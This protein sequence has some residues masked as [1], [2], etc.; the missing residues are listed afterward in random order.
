MQP[1]NHI[2]KVL[3]LSIASLVMMSLS[4]V[5]NAADLAPEIT[6]GKGEACVEDKD[7]MRRNHMDL[8]RH[9][10]DETVHKGNRDIKHSLKDCISCHAIDGSDGKALTVS[11]PK[12]FCRSCH[13]Y[14]AVS[15]DCFQCHASRPELETLD[16]SSEELKKVHE[17]KDSLF[18][19]KEFEDKDSEG[20][21]K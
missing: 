1:N 9:D 3:K 12:H 10:R 15:V 14:A 19:N 6:P 5:I 4:M 7:F 18:E 8:L 16:M 17:N 2:G 13:D 21:D 20:K 11:S